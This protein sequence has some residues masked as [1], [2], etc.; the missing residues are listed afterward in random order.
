VIGTIVIIE[1][2]GPSCAGKTSL[3]QGVAETLRRDGIAIEVYSGK[4]VRP[5]RNARIGLI[6]RFS[7]LRLSIWSVVNPA[8][9][10][11][12]SGRQFSQSLALS[13]R[14][15]GSGVVQILDEGPLKWSSTV[16]QGSKF[17]NT[18]VSCIPRPDIAVLVDCDFDVRLARLRSAG[19]FHARARTEDELRAR[20]HAKREWNEW[21]IDRLKLNVIRV[22]TSSSDDRSD[23]VAQTVRSRFLGQAA[24]E[25]RGFTGGIA[26]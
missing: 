10:D 15:R 24:T 14:L 4:A 26:E 2:F 19:R 7:D 17:P 13:T 21:L 25:R 8:V 20:D 23:H 6:R 1:V 12:P 3:I 18:L 9:A 16:G 5:I 22:D 11:S